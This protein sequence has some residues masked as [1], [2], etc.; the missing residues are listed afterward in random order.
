MSEHTR[1]QGGGSTYPPPQKKIMK[2]QKNENSSKLLEHPFAE[3]FSEKGVAVGCRL[4]RPLSGKT[5]LV[6]NESRFRRS[7]K[8]RDQ[9]FTEEFSD[10]GWF[11]SGFTTWI[12]QTVY[13]YF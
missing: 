12:T 5:A 4:G 3:E 2:T 1:A 11:F 6:G 8:P 10:M 7:K 9:S 13:C